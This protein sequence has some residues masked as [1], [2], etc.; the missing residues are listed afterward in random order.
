MIDM[1]SGSRRGIRFSSTAREHDPYSMM[2]DKA[3]LLR[4]HT[5]ITECLR[6]LYNGTG[7]PEPLTHE[8]S[9]WWSCRIN[10]EPR[11]VYRLAEDTLDI[12]AHR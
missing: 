7:K 8:F 6:N 2:R 9:G 10:Q 11:L 12:A 1:A 3:T 4:I 5:L